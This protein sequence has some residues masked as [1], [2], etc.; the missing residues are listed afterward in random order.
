MATGRY[1]KSARRFMRRLC[2]HAWHLILMISVGQC[3]RGRGNVVLCQQDYLLETS[4]TP[5]VTG[6]LDWRRMKCGGVEVT[7]CTHECTEDAV[8]AMMKMVMAGQLT[9]WPTGHLVDQVT[10]LVVVA[11][12]WWQLFG[13]D[14]TMSSSC[15]GCSKK[16]SIK[17]VLLSLSGPL[18]FHDMFSYACLQ[19]PMKTPSSIMM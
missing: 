9:A 6:C 10:N 4:K 12:L 17:T 19:I 11:S 16:Q 7:L 18:T 15:Y 5:V 13:F 1:R 14:Q 3:G 8:F 2:G